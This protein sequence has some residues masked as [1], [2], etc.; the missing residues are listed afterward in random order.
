MCSPIPPLE[1]Q[2]PEEVTQRTKSEEMLLRFFFL[3]A[4]LLLGAD[5]CLPFGVKVARAWVGENTSE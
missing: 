5:P 3:L 4:V 1:Q 2:H